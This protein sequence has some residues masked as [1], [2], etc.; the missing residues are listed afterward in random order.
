MACTI[1][2]RTTRRF[3]FCAVLGQPDALSAGAWAAF[4][5]P[6]PTSSR[7]QKRRRSAARP[8]R[9]ARRTACDR[10]FCRR[11][12]LAQGAARI[13][14][15]QAAR[16][17]PAKR[18]RFL[19]GGSGGSKRGIGAF[20]RTWATRCPSLWRV[21]SSRMCQNAAIQTVVVMGPAPGGASR[22]GAFL[23]AFWGRRPGRPLVRGVFRIE[24]VGIVVQ[25]SLV[26][27]S[28]VFWHAG[29]RNG[30]C[31]NIPC[32]AVNVRAEC[33]S[34]PSCTILPA[35]RPSF[36]TIVH[37]RPVL[38]ETPLRARGAAWRRLP[39]IDAEPRAHRGSRHAPARWRAAGLAQAESPAAAY[40]P[41][42]GAGLPTARP[43]LN[44]RGTGAT[45]EF[46]DP[47][48]A[49]LPGRGC[50]L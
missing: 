43:Q 9:P 27:L 5:R 38:S 6:K 16:S 3:F 35:I 26:G 19:R 4:L 48:R 23:G 41:P 7:I 14:R 20:A 30:N 36:R 33:P 32:N 40:E 49:A 21:P 31:L 28:G 42:Q 47:A 50:N 8:V 37:R 25:V 1:K 12:V 46:V 34:R 13:V 15:P 45:A 22:S 11:P 24:L 18:R 39:G 17:A 29:A 10:L 2:D 44:R